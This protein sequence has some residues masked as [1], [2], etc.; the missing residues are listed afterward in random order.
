ME[1]NITIYASESGELYTYYGGKRQSLYEAGWA[2][3]FKEAV[4]C[5]LHELD[6]G[7]CWFQ[8]LDNET[9]E[10]LESGTFEPNEA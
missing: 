5:A 10:V 7:H 9:D 8:V 6:T 3:S 2:P 1:K 4:F